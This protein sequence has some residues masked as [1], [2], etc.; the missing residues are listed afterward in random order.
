MKKIM[1]TLLAVSILDAATNSAWAI[2]SG[3]A[4]K[5]IPNRTCRLLDW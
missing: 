5:N 1:A 2:T 4:R 3:N